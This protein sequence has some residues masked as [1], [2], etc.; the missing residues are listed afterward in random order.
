MKIGQDNGY[1]ATKIVTE[2]RRAHFPSV[3]GTPTRAAFSVNGH[4]DEIRISAAG[5]TWLVGDSAVNQSRFLVRREDRN[6]VESDEYYVITLAGMSELTTASVEVQLVTGLPVA[7]FSD[8]RN[9]KRRLMGEHK[10]Q[11]AGRN[12]QT[13]RI[14][15]V[16]VVPQPFGA[17]LNEALDQRGALTNTEYTG[18]VGVIDI[19]GKTTNLLSAS[20]LA[21]VPNE[22]TSINLGGWDIIRQLRDHLSEAIPGLELRDHELAAVLQARGVKVAGEWVDL[23]GLSAIIE[24]MADQVLATARQLWGSALKLDVILIAGGGAHLIGPHLQLRFK[25]ARVVEHPVYAN[26]TGFW[27]LAQR[28]G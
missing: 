21:E 22:T 26:A 3:V 9:L 7:Y 5:Q 27:K 1:N 8:H 28:L 15:D 2:G 20:K 24:P 10:F 19:G 25:Q 11:R 18:R 14:S 16:R 12:A 4:A 23:P 6:W 17:L 13:V